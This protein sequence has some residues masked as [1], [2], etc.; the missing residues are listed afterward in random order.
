MPGWCDMVIHN[1]FL[2]WKGVIEKCSWAKDLDFSECLTSEKWDP[3]FW[4]NKWKTK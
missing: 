4:I 2:K 1:S 3:Q